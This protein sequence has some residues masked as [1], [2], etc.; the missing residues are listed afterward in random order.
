MCYFAHNSYVS[1][2]YK[3]TYGMIY[4]IR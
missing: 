3:F 2:H 1:M 4:I